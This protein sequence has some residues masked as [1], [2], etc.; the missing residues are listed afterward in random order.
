MT[1]AKTGVQRREG[2]ARSRGSGL[3]AL[4]LADSSTCFTQ[5]GGSG[6]DEVLNDRPVGVA[7]TPFRRFRIRV[8]VGR[9]ETGRIQLNRLRLLLR[10]PDLAALAGAHHDRAES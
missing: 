6:L 4:P 9:A 1:S 5:D 8:E 7:L 10:S 3:E 2:N